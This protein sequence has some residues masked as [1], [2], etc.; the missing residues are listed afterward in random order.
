[1][2]HGEDVHECLR[3]ERWSWI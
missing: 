3:R 1:M 2:D